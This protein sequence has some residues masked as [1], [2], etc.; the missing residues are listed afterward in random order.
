MVPTNTKGK[1]EICIHTAYIQLIQ[2][3]YNTHLIWPF[4]CFIS[5]IE[6]SER[7]Q[8]ISPALHLCIVYE[9]E[10]TRES[11]EYINSNNITKNIGAHCMCTVD[12][13]HSKLL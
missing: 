1:K 10:C 2:N 8:L 12:N 13:S 11:G 4:E 6:I 9:Y 3:E 7:N 5:L